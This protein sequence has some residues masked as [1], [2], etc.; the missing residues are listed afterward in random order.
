MQ[1]RLRGAAL[2]ASLFSVGPFQSKASFLL[3]KAA[4]TLTDLAVRQSRP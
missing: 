2:P 1:L 4:L 3:S